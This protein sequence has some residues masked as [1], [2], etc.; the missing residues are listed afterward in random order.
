MSNAI[1]LCHYR[2]SI[3]KFLLFQWLN[4]QTTL[5]FYNNIKKLNANKVGWILH[6]NR[7]KKTA[8]ICF[9]NYTYKKKIHEKNHV[10][11]LVNIINDSYLENINNKII[12]L[13]L[14]MYTVNLSNETE[15]H[16]SGTF[17]KSTCKRNITIPQLTYI[18][19]FMLFLKSLQ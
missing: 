16:S 6:M 17:L 14:N 3:S 18:I 8:R 13:S 15:L 19:Y 11:V 2:L 1:I 9:K 10:K 4:F 5:H 12:N 7:K